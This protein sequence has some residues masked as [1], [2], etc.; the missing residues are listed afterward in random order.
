MSGQLNWAGQHLFHRLGRA[1]LRPL[2]KHGHARFH[3][4]AQVVVSLQYFVYVRSAKMSEQVLESVTWW[5]N[6]LK[7]DIVEVVMTFVHLHFVL[8]LS[9][10]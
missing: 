2:F 3:T 7:H 1:M 9:P 8:F 6:I 5:L 10:L 4:S